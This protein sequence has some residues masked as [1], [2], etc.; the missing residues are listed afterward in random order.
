MP[1]HNN[2]KFCNAT[3]KRSQNQCRNLAV[4]DSEKCRMHGGATP[5]GIASPHFQTGKYS[6]CLPARLAA[7]YEE[8]LND[9]KLVE[10]TDEIVLID[11]LLDERLSRVYQG[12]STDFWESL[13]ELQKQSAKDLKKL[14]DLMNERD[15][16]FDELCSGINEEE[17]N[18]K[19]KSA[20]GK[21]L[22]GEDLKKTKAR[23][24]TVS[25]EIHHLLKHGQQTY[26]IF[27]EIEPMLEQ[28]RK[29]CETEMRRKEKL[30]Q[31]IPADRAFAMVVRIADIV[32]RHIHEPEQLR[33]ICKELKETVTKA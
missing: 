6:R 5:M 8:R 12:E 31:M 3:S 25:K 23:F 22:S 16:L 4:T 11:V 27:D 32:K 10:L 9:P 2:S 30:G 17:N 13:D 21:A 19:R 15:R 20:G 24:E 29:L 7:R 26:S 28:R 18:G 33:E 14:Q 1:L